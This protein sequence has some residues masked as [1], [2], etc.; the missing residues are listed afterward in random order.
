M[1]LHAEDHAAEVDYGKIPLLCLPGLTRDSRD[2]APALPHLRQQ[3]RVILMDLRGRGRSSHA[4]DPASYRP[5]VEAND[6]LALLSHIKIPKVAIIGTSRGGIVGM[7]LAA[8]ARTHVAGLLLNDVGPVLEKHGLLRIKGYLGKQPAFASFEAA[9]NA[10]KQDQQGMLGL[11]DTEW[12]AFARRIFR[13]DNGI[14]RLSYDPKLAVT[15][16]SEEQIE[17]ATG[18]ELWPFFDTLDAMPLAV[19]RGENSDLLSAATVEEMKFRMPQLL[20]MTVRGRAHV[21]F[22]DEPQSISLIAAFLDEVD[23][24]QD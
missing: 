12:L 6:V 9:A 13:D 18:Q 16:P 10:L 2:F 20:A 22:L 11:S 23:S 8:T 24:V 5:D 7:L 3:R 17:A 19:L 1:R 21:P 14:P 15:F 4:D